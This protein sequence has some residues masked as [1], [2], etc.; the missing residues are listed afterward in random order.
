MIWPYLR[1]LTRHAAYT[2]YYTSFLPIINKILVFVVYPSEHIKFLLL[3]C[4]I[5]SYV[6]SFGATY[7]PLKIHGPITRNPVFITN[8]IHRRLLCLGPL[9]EFHTEILLGN[10][11]EMNSV[12]KSMQNLGIQNLA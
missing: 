9:P 10:V 4:C 7:F 12:S 8:L 2:T 3:N 11:V 5:L 6:V 1:I